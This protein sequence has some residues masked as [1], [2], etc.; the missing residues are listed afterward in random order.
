M[1]QNLCDRLLRL[2]PVDV[3]AR[4]K[5]AQERSEKRGTEREQRREAE[6]VTGTSPSHP[7]A[8]YAGTY[9][10]PAYGPLT[11]AENAGQLTMAYGFQR[12][13]FEH[14]HYDVFRAVKTPDTRDWDARGRLTFTSNAAGRIES[15]AAPLEPAMP[16]GV[17]FKRKP[18]SSGTSSAGQ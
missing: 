1:T 5:A 7:L 14:F 8:D 6:R 10:H 12:R 16:G 9:E 13:G 11:I 2:P 18:A 17:I 3:I 15:V 4:V